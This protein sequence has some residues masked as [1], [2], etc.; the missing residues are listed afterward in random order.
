MTH[1]IEA[2]ERTTGKRIVVVVRGPESLTLKQ[3]VAVVRSMPEFKV[4]D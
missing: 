2:V 4:E 3:A 1:N